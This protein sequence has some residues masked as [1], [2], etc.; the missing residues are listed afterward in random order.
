MTVSLKEMK[1]RLGLTPEQLAKI[2]ERTQQ[3]IDEELTLRELRKVHRLTQESMASLLGIEQDSVSRMER[4]ADMLLSTMISYVAAMGGRL[5]LV[6]ESPDRAPV[7]VKLSDLNDEEPV[8]KRRV[9]RAKKVEQL[10]PLV[11][12]EP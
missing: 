6:A 8:S 2:D 9:S 3:L 4:R 10:T 11:L 12:A 5:R 1:K 7:E